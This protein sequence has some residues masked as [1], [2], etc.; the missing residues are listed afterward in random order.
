[1]ARG[2]SIDEATTAIRETLSGLRDELPRDL[3]A[4]TITPV[5]PDGV[6]E[7]TALAATKGVL[8]ALIVGGVLAVVIVYLFLNSWSSAVITGLALPVSILG[9]FATLSAFGAGLDSMTLLGLVL[10]LGVLLDDTVVVRENA[11]RHMELGRDARRAARVGAAEMGRAM[12]TASVALVVAFVPVVFAG[13]LATGWL[14]AFAL[15]MGSATILSLVVSLSLVP[16]LSAAW[17]D[18]V[19]SANRGFSALVDAF[20]RWLDRLGDGYH[21][22]LAWTLDHKRTMAG[23]GV[24]AFATALVVHERVGQVPGEGPAVASHAK[25]I[26][27]VV[28]GPDASTLSGVAQRVADELRLVPGVV[29]PSL[30]TKTG[31]SRAILAAD[32]PPRPPRIE[33]LDGERIVRIHAD[34]EG[35]ALGD[36]ARDLEARSRNL[37][38]PPGYRVSL[39]GFIA[40][41]SELSDRIGIGLAIAILLVYAVLAMQLRSLVDPLAILLPLPLA[42]TGG[43]LALAVSGD[44]IDLFNLL[45]VMLLVGLAVRNGVFLI[46]FARRRRREGA[47][48]RVAIIEAARLRF[49]P[50]IMTTGALAAAMV[51]LSIAG[52]YASLAREVIGG[53]LSVALVT[54]LVVPCLSAALARPGPDLARAWRAT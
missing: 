9:T 25:P 48:A 8:R 30:S 13:G 27:L 10:A 49:R 36:V 3:R 33:H 19:A 31:G 16:M 6:A 46:V 23:L 42:L 24:L 12:A 22:T 40:V 39:G 51:P 41:Q 21:E 11:V 15:S 5:S 17:R 4:P 32:L 47:N 45:A 14:K 43:V 34:V 53:V 26:E 52:P 38:L 44:A 50:I 28:R 1:L 20:D 54:L 7:S 18:P 37:D 2:S 35:R 29:D